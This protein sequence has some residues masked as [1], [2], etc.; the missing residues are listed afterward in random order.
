MFHDPQVILF[1]ED[2]ERSANSY[3]GLGFVEAFRVPIGLPPRTGRLLVDRLYT[4]IADPS[5]S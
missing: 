4:R 1:S 2:V 3:T 5:G